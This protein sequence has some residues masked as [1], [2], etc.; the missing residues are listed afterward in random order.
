MP[1]SQKSLDFLL[2]NRIMN[3]K[4]WFEE[5]RH[6]YDE[7]V[8]TPLRELVVAL[9]PAI[10][11]IDP[12]LICEPKISRSIS[13]IYRDTRFS[14]DKSI[15]REVMW[16]TFIRDRKQMLSGIPGFY[17]EIS[18]A[19]FSHGC[20]CYRMAA[21]LMDQVRQLILADDK[22]FLAARRAWEK[23][24]IFTLEDT[25]YKRT[26]HPEA[27]EK[28]RLWLDQRGI[29]LTADSGDLDTLFSPDLY[30]KLGEDFLLLEPVYKFLMKA[31][32]RLIRTP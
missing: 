29:I 32:S 19:G 10:H 17:F 2:E 9:E 30:K 1:F 26:R 5:H 8:L 11:S 7:H 20:G 15:F 31:E 12:F 18:P 13:R 16:L 23:Q 4:L 27:T 14:R 25:R 6:I 22:S 21:E 3:S 24:S 28:Q